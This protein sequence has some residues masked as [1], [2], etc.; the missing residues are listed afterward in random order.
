MGLGTYKKIFTILSGVT[1]IYQE[2][3]WK[4]TYYTK[5]LSCDVTNYIISSNTVERCIEHKEAKGK[6]VGKNCLFGGPWSVCLSDKG[7]YE[8]HLSLSN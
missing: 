4:S 2:N 8:G 3:Y 6:K 5:F 1:L 7:S